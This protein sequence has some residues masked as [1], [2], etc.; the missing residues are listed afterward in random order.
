M[1]LDSDLSIDACEIAIFEL[2]PVHFRPAEESREE[3]TD[4]EIPYDI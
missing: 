1:L 3:N 2:S 4:T